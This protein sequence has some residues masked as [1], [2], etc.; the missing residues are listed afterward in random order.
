MKDKGGR[1]HTS[2][3]FK[4]HLLEAPLSAPDF[5]NETPP[6]VTWLGIEGLFPSLDLSDK[7]QKRVTAHQKLRGL[8]NSKT[9]S[10]LGFPHHLF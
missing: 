9:L 1:K 6:G 5:L 3:R 8:G 2:P 4:D 10:A 7:E